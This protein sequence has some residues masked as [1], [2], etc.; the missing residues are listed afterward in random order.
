MEN[1]YLCTRIL[2]QSNMIT[3]EEIKRMAERGESFNVD[4]KVVVPQKVR[5]ITEEVCSFANAA[6]GF[7]LIG[8]DGR[9]VIKGTT[10]DNSKRSAIQDSIGEISPA[11]HT[12]LYSVDVDGKEVWVVEIPAGRQV[13]YFF[14][15]SVFVREGA[16]SQKLT[17]VEEIRELFQQAEKIYYDS[18]SNKKYNIYEHLDADITRWRN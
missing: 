9:G 12:E 10:I 17:N 13:P 7:V 5:D 14:G 1:T 6:G 15:G 11:L 18:I 8:I 16:N 4:F 3:A 2:N